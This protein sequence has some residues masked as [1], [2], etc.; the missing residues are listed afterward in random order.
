MDK[1]IGKVLDD[2]YEI[3]ELIGVGGMSY[4]YKAKCRRLSRYV[5]VKI[6]KREFA[7]DQEFIKRF[8]NE[9]D[10][11]ARLSHK[12]IVN[13]F[14]VSNG[15][16]LHYIVMEF[17][18]GITLKDFLIKKKRLDWKQTLFF[19][20]QIAEGLDHAHSRGIIHQ[21]IKPH[22]IMLLRDGTLKV[23]DFGIAKLEN[24]GETKVIKEAIGSVHYVSPE[25]AKGSTIDQR[26][27]IY[28]LGVVMY[29][30]ITGKTPYT[31]DNAIAIVMQHINSMPTPP[32]VLNSNF[33]KAFEYV[34]MKAMNHNIR[35]RYRDCKE[36]ISDLE[37]VKLNPNVLL[38]N[39]KIQEIT[40]TQPISKDEIRSYVANNLENSHVLGVKMK[41][42]L[43]NFAKNPVLPKNDKGYIKANDDAFD[44]F[45]D[46][47]NYDENNYNDDEHYDDY[48]DGRDNRRNSR[49]DEYYDDDYEYER[50]P[51]RKKNK[52]KKIAQIAIAV[53]LLLAILSGAIWF[54]VSK[55]FVTQSDMMTVPQLVSMMFSDVLDDPNYADFE[56]LIKEEIISEF[57]EGTI[58]SQV[59]EADKM[60]VVGGKIYVVVSSGIKKI[61][62]PKLTDWEYTSAEAELNRLGI[63]NVKIQFDYSPDFEKGKVISSNPEQG[64]EI[65]GES[66]ITLLVSAGKELVL[67][68]VPD[69]LGLTIEEANTKLKDNDLIMGNV[70]EQVSLSPAGTI[71]NQGIQ[72]GIETTSETKVDVVIAKSADVALETKTTNITV[73]VPSD[74]DDETVHMEVYVDNDNVYSKVHDVGSASFNVKISGTDAV[75]VTI[76]A[77]GSLIDEK[78]IDFD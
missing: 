72:A 54:A 59:P 65:D 52:N 28:S 41:E 15:R 58:I 12:N 9:S 70:T 8:K 1:F 53:V 39:T 44:N 69:L 34:I 14:D 46:L 71:I 60:L 37:K 33:P 16:E 78:V 27:D 25:Q 73:D 18:D 47:D 7:S 17:V 38:G 32:S 10:A 57:A 49:D 3:V 68:T 75:M 56:I 11:V 36:M 13:V 29:E 61:D 74:M 22:N 76:Y 48:D 62:M 21:D 40:H 4:V 50:R 2:R 23:A 42:D 20:Y 45:D 55:V 19:T 43:D 63:A 35:N 26:S 77:N 64:T 30:M 6:L 51:K 67:A 66:V 24:E 31:G 5:A